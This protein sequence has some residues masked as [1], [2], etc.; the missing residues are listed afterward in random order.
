ME[1]E[2]RTGY[3]TPV[4]RM[5]RRGLDA[6]GRSPATGPSACC[7]RRTPR[8]HY[9]REL[10]GTDFDFSDDFPIVYQRFGV[11]RPPTHAN[12]ALFPFP[13]FPFP[14]K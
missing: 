3:A 11:V 10:A 7:R 14:P 5:W 1:A 9:Q 6:L 12:H 13:S 8:A 2:R 4:H